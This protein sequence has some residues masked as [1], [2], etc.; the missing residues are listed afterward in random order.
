MRAPM[1]HLMSSVVRVICYFGGSLASPSSVRS[2][3][4]SKRNRYRDAQ[5]ICT[6]TASC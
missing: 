3:A 2:G 6:A 1:L 4:C 5:L